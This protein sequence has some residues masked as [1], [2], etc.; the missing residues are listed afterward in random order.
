MLQLQTSQN[1]HFAKEVV[2]RG[3]VIVVASEGERIDIP[4]GAI[5]ENAVVTGNLRSKCNVGG[6]GEWRVR[7]GDICFQTIIDIGTL[8]HAVLEH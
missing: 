3:T 2:L 6:V 7:G 1:V 8:I 5:L 4:R